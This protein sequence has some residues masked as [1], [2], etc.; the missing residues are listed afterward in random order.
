MPKIIVVEDDPAIRELIV[1]NLEKEK[2]I[3]LGFAE[4]IPAESYVLKNSADLIILDLML[5][6]ID[7]LELCKVLKRSDPTK[8]IPIIML[9]AKGDETDRILGLELGADDYIVKPFSPKELMARI[10]A[11]LR[12]VNFRAEPAVYTR[13]GITLDPIKYTVEFQERP[14]SVTAT[15]F[16]ILETL[17]RSPGRVFTR[18]MLLETLSKLVVDRNIDVHVTAL[19]KK[20]GAGGRHI[21]TIRGV[22]Y[23]LEE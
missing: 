20:L 22:G 23:K 18:H 4:G 8:S 5:P 3:A 17:I 21:K 6:D 19:R 12:R 2:Y 7:G 15:E 14:V 9:T 13:H 1:F 11:V 16:K 10:K